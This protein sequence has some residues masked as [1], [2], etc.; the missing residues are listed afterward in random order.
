MTLGLWSLWAK[1]SA[2]GNAKRFPRQATRFAGRR[3]VHKSTAPIFGFGVAA[4][5]T[6]GDTKP[7]GEQGASRR[8]SLTTRTVAWANKPAFLQGWV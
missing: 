1:G 7:V 8:L 4:R 5:R 3:I 2:V 6:P